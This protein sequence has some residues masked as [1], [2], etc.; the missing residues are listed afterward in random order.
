[1]DSGPTMRRTCAR[2]QVTLERQAARLACSV[3]AKRVAELVLSSKYQAAP[4]RHRCARRFPR[5][6][7][8]W[9]P[10]RADAP[11]Q[12]QL[13]ARS[14]RLS[15]RAKV[16]SSPSCSASI[17]QLAASMALSERRT[18]PGLRPAI[19]PAVAH[20]VPGARGPDGQDSSQATSVLSRED[21][22]REDRRPARGCFHP[23]HTI[24]PS[25]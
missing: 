7:Q 14:A 1:M 19:D 12:P 22:G 25:D 20:T 15:Q 23:R 6:A 10:A 4:L 8:P 11:G 17:V 24:S 13:H 16:R 2:G 21:R 18:R 9:W 3:S 5:R